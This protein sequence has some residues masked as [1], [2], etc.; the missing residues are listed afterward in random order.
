MSGDSVADI[1]INSD[2][3]DQDHPELQEDCKN[4]DL[5]NSYNY[6][7]EDV[8]NTVERARDSLEGNLDQSDQNI[9][10]NGLDLDLVNNNNCIQDNSKQCLDDTEDD[11]L[12]SPKKD[13]HSF[14]KDNDKNIL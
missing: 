6:V 2:S 14:V 5:K 13:I 1:V 10:G 3:M 9:H 12:K 11:L 8:I 7:Q 4:G